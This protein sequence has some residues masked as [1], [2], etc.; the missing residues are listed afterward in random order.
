[1]T[2]VT[3][4]HPM[5][6]L[7]AQAAAEPGRPCIVWRDG[8]ARIELSATSAWNYAVKAANLL[9]EEF[10]LAAGGRVQLA[11]PPHWQTA[12]LVFGVW[13]A[14]GCVSDEVQDCDMTIGVAGEPADAVTSLDP[15]G[16]PCAGGVP[17]GAVDLGRELRGQ[18]DVLLQPRPLDRGVAA[19]VG[20][21]DLRFEQLRDGAGAWAGTRI[22]LAADPAARSVGTAFIRAAAAAACGS[23]LVICGPGERDVV[24]EQEHIDL[25]V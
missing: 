23:T 16:G 17:A 25:W 13:L 21:V 22:G 1:V 11:L 8:P 2:A 7:K 24:Q 3:S 10:D 5:A 18:P 6:Q 4:W 12:G 14:G 9:A 15:W 20:G 19:R